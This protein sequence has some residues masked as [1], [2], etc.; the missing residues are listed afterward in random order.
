VWEVLREDEFSPLK[1]ADGAEKDTPTTARHALYSLHQRYI[2]SAGGRFIDEA[3]KPIPLIP[4]TLN[5]NAIELETNNNETQ[6]SSSSYTDPIV[7]EISPLI[8]YTGE[9]L[10]ACVSSMDFRPPVAFLAQT[11]NV[12]RDIDEKFQQN[13]NVHV[14][15][16][17]VD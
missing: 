7:V 10:E 3:G 13:F 5:N 6:K 12:T 9:R 1:N 11:E 15:D 16:L 8:T 14:L 4:S 2:L 17:D